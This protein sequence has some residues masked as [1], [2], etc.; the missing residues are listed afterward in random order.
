MLLTLYRTY[1]T[2]FYFF[3][4]V[5]FTLFLLNAVEAVQDRLLVTGHVN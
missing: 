5:I 3:L 2:P 1:S 4:S